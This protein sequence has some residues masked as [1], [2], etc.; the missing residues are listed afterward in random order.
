MKYALITPVEF[1]DTPSENTNGWFRVWAV[2][3]SA[4]PGEGMVYAYEPI[5]KW[6]FA[7]GGFWVKSRAVSEEWLSQLSGMTGYIDPRETPL[8]EKWAR[9]VVEEVSDKADCGTQYRWFEVTDEPPEFNPVY[10]RRYL[11]PHGEWP[12][13]NF[14]NGEVSIHA[15]Y[16]VEDIAIDD[17]RGEYE[18]QL[19]IE[20]AN[21]SK[22]I[23]LD[24][25]NISINPTIYAY[26]QNE[27]F[28]AISSGGSWGGDVTEI[29]TTVEGEIVP[30]LDPSLAY[31]KLSRLLSWMFAMSAHRNRLFR[32]IKTA[33]TAED[34]LAIDLKAGWPDKA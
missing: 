32:A 29:L 31:V 5:W 11:E 7:E 34:L 2:L 15:L 8:H 26:A 13:Y 10:Q 18:F 17:V 25:A 27:A 20:Y 24:G 14:G 28:K 21:R 23:D 4:P 19:S 12:V 16:T 22:S 6:E 3:P 30:L 9:A 33:E 1:A